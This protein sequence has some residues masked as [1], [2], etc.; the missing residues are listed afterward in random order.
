[1]GASVTNERL[2]LETSFL[3]LAWHYEGEWPFSTGA[4][5]HGLPPFNTALRQLDNRY[6]RI[7]SGSVDQSNQL[8][9]LVPVGRSEV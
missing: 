2:N 5:I 8:Q 7:Q 6:R 4:S 3:N 9:Y 1:M